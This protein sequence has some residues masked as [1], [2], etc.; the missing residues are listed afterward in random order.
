[1]IAFESAH[2]D[3][4]TTHIPVM[5]AEILDALRPQPGGVFIDGTLGG[6]GHTALLLE[7]IGPTGR[8]LAIDADPAA[9][10][11]AEAR[12][13]EA[14]ALGRLQLHHANFRQ[15]AEVAR[16]AGV[17]PVDGVLLDLGLSSDQL[18]ARERGFS[19][20]AE[21]ALDMRFDPTRG[22]SAAELVNSLSDTELADIFW[23]YGEER[24]SRPI[25]R[26][27]VETRS[28]A[29]I[30]RADELARLVAGAV[31]GRPGG[32]HPATRVFQALRIAVND[33]LG[34]LEAALPAALETLKPGGRLAV[35]SFHSL[36][37][38][39][40]KQFFQREQRGCICP[41]EA[42]QCVCGHAPR[43]RII[44]RHPLTAS[45]AEVAANP[46]ARSAKLRVAERL[47]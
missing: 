34:S 13:A 4:E 38:R 1:M 40:V 26:R 24:F 31:H 23:R 47:D 11:R 46:R 7:R 22:E 37:D 6:A 42:P 30:T 32:V 28:R 2:A 36:E 3:G 17:A 44:T 45:E 39:I 14:V 5:P 21:G 35:I 10:R 27:I 29:P 12:L 15:L 19:F 20:A 18:A 8:V 41:P 33:E 25:A 9:L 16:V 43:L